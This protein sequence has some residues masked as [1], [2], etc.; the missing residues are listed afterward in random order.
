MK[1]QDAM[2]KLTRCHTGCL[3]IHACASEYHDRAHE[4]FITTR[5]GELEQTVFDLANELKLAV[6]YLREGKA[7][8]TPGTTNSHV[9]DF[10]SKHLDSEE[11]ST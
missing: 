2:K 1:Q 8:F 3:M 4:R 5:E 9:D 11:E 6:Q 7:K 10:L